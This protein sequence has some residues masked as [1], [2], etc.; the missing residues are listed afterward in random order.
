MNENVNGK[1]VNQ[2]SQRESRF[3]TLFEF[4]PD[5]IVVVDGKHEIIMVNDKTRQLT[6][7]SKEELLKQ[8][9]EKLI[10]EEYSAG[11]VEW[12]NEYEHG[13]RPNAHRRGESNDVPCRRR[14]GTTFPAEISVRPFQSDE[15][16][17]VFC[18]IRDITE[19]KQAESLQRLTAA[20]FASTTDGI[21]VTDVNG[22]IQNINNAC[23]Q[24]TGYTLSEVIGKNLRILKS[25]LQDESFYASM[26][27]TLR[28]TGTWK[29]RFMNQRKSG[30]VY[31]QEMT[32]NAIRT[33]RGE[34]AQYCGI[35]RDV[36]EQMK[37][38]ERLDKLSKTDSLTGLANRRSFDEALAVE[39]RRALRTNTPLALIMADIDTFK[40]LNDTY[41]H[42][43]GD[44]CLKEISNVLK[45][46][47]RRAG[48]LAAR[49]GGDEFI[50]LLPITNIIE[51][52]KIAQEIKTDVEM[53]KLTSGESG[54]AIL[55]TLSMGIAANVPNRDTSPEAL[56][57]MADH[58]LYRAKQTGRNRIEIAA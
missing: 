38:E 14:D 15:G 17:M 4:A 52:Q 27:Q 57:A 19:R 54:M 13:L 26:W 31:P 37:L 33:S 45:K 18:I 49:Y 40:E 32:I 56:I 30:E 41:G 22:V 10:P 29:G 2:V 1:N 23:T 51:A 46:A 47:A 21:V 16:L 34:T 9:I 35:F 43:T 48:N 50:L 3:R 20:V 28:K 8:P 25:G 6:G 36:T 7:Y 11:H 44:E 24:I 58:A 55:I 53:I 5:G 39:W 42:L 12:R